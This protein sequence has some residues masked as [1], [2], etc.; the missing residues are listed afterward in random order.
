MEEG[1]EGLAS[2]ITEGKH[3]SLPKIGYRKGLI[4][5]QFYNDSI[6]GEI[7]SSIRLNE[8]LTSN[9]IHASDKWINISLLQ[10]TFSSTI[11]NFVEKLYCSIF[12]FGR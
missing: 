11:R 3:I 4:L 8:Q 9:A 10:R 7:L 5:A 12:P 2:K 6:R 1:R